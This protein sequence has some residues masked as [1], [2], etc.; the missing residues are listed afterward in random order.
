L[1]PV[2]RPA[3]RRPLSAGRRAL[4]LAGGRVRDLGDGHGH[5]DLLLLSQDLEG[6]GLADC[7]LRHQALH[8]AVVLHGDLVVADDHVALR[9]PVVAAG[10]AGGGEPT[11]APFV[12]DSPRLW[13]S[14]VD[15]GCSET[16]SQP[17]TTLPLS[18]S[19]SI[20][21]LTILI[22]MAKPMP[23]PAATIAVLIPIT[24]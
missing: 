10:P 17:R 18:T 1:E 21:R 20:T 12:L 24:S 2:R 7:A 3:G 8:V 22:G 13:A 4:G 19:W 6:D 16:P 11:T 15:R 9:A 23:C 5:V 14:S